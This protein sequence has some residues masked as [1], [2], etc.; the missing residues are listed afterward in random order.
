[1]N[2]YRPYGARALVKLLPKTERVLPSGLAVVRDDAKWHNDGL[3]HEYAEIVA[4][5]GDAELRE[6]FAPAREGDVVIIRAG[7]VAGVESG[8]LAGSKVDGELIVVLAREIV[9]VVSED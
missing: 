7:G 8:G 5:P 4:L 1:V 9:A 3:D 6:L 2:E